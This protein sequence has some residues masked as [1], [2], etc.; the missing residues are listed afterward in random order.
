M[1][2]PGAIGSSGAGPSR[3]EPGI[4]A[5]SSTPS[6]VARDFTTI[7]W[8]WMRPSMSAQ[9]FRE[10]REVVHRPD[11]AVLHAAM[12]DRLV[13]RLHEHLQPRTQLGET[14]DL[15]GVHLA[16]RHVGIHV[17]LD[18][19]LDGPHAVLELLALV[20]VLRDDPEV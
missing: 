10:D 9:P 19:L 6:A 2:P 11:A 3:N 4:G 15:V 8:R 1:R 17:R 20:V 18:A 5:S 7:S 16:R 12:A 14:D 13:A